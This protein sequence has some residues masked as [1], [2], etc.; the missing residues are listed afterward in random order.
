MWQSNFLSIFIALR[1]LF[2]RLRLNCFLLNIYLLYTMRSFFFGYNFINCW[3]KSKCVARY[4]HNVDSSLAA[5]L[6][7]IFTRRSAIFGLSV[8][9]GT[10]ESKAYRDIK[11]QSINYNRSEQHRIEHSKAPY[12]ERIFHV[13]MVDNLTANSSFRPIRWQ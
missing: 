5:P 4:L 12:N 11:C 7:V 13:N 1:L 3:C 6:P 9:L 8:G 2:S 10:C